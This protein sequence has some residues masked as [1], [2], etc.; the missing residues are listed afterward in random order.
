MEAKIS[1]GTARILV[2]DDD[3]TFRLLARVSLE[4]AGFRVIEAENGMQALDL[5]KKKHPDIILLDVVMPEMD[6]LTACTQL[7]K[8]PEGKNIPIVIVT[9][10][11]DTSSIIQAYKAGATDFMEKPVNWI[12]AGYRLHF[13]L[14]AVRQAGELAETDSDIFE[15]L[16]TSEKTEIRSIRKVISTE[17]F[18]WLKDLRELELVVGSEVLNHVMKNFIHGT[19]KIVQHLHHSL[20]SEE[21]EAII[22]HA[23][24]LQSQCTT[25]NTTRLVPLCKELETITPEASSSSIEELITAIETE[26]EL[27]IELLKE[28][29][30]TLVI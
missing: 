28:E 2:V 8:L 29:F 13:I 5:F 10:L 23:R 7:R 4:K 17:Q 6:G 27:V 16:S 20:E 9:A 1:N 24:N 12:I 22:N 21:K 25:L 19:A 30:S 3:N 11:G 14:R 15:D 26:R 18:A